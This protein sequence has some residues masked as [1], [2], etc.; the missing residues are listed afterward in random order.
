MTHR[1][2]GRRRCPPCLIG[3]VRGAAIASRSPRWPPCSFPP[4]AHGPSVLSSSCKGGGAVVLSVEATAGPLL[5]HGHTRLCHTP[6][7]QRL[8]QRLLEKDQ[9]P[10]PTPSPAFSNNQTTGGSQDR[11]K[12]A[13]TEQTSHAVLSCCIERTQLIRAKKQLS[14]T[15]KVFASTFGARYI[16]RVSALVVSTNNYRPD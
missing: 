7:H 10:R 9:L 4:L 6:K 8:H 5:K 2:A 15:H 13:K 14:H 1:V 3:V 12:H 16:R 11:R